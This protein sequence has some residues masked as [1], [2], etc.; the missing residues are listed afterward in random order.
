[1]S[2]ADFLKDSVRF[3]GDC[4]DSTSKATGGGR[5]DHRPTSTQL[6]RKRW[7]ALA[8]GTLLSPAIPM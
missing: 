7:L 6:F 3:S 2:L 5:A 4:Y 8:A 1:M